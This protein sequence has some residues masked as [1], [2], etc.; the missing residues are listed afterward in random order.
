MNDSSNLTEDAIAFWNDKALPV[1]NWCTDRWMECYELSAGWT[2]GITIVV[3]L[4][5]LSL[6]GDDEDKPAKPKR[7]RTAYAATVSTSEPRRAAP[8]RES[9]VTTTWS[10]PAPAR[11][12]EEPKPQR[13]YEVKYIH[14]SN[15]KTVHTLN[16]MIRTNSATEARMMVENN[17]TSIPFNSMNQIVSIRKR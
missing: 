7:T 9:T 13:T 16:C 1:I 3:G 4:Y 17:E 2:V 8:R 14:T 15:P 5:I 6:F 12:K 10:S 11:V